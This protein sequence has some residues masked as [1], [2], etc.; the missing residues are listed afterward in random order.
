MFI[1][2]PLA[3]ASIALTLAPDAASPEPSPSPG[4]ESGSVA[5]GRVIEDATESTTD[6]DGAAPADADSPEEE[7]SEPGA[8]GGFFDVDE[9]RDS[10]SREPTAPPMPEIEQLPSREGA[11]PPMPEI[12]EL[13][14]RGEDQD[15][16][17]EG[18]RRRLFDLEPPGPDREPAGID[19]GSFFDP[20]KLEDTGPSGGAIQIRGYVAANFFVTMRTNTFAREDDGT[21]ERLSPQ[22]FFDVS[23]AT[24]TWARR[25]SPTWSTRG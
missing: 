4:S 25:S 14:P 5:D 18:K 2:L 17:P 10:D 1:S 16:A 15:E 11:A 9:V 7:G 3:V 21:F 22:P 23:S 8:G 24:C 12:E 20:G 19:G 13:P 6:P